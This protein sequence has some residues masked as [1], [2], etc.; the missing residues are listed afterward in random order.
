LSL[1]PISETKS[2]FFYLFY[3]PL[4]SIADTVHEEQKLNNSRDSTHTRHATELASLVE[5]VD[6]KEPVLPP[7]LDS[8]LLLC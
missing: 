2:S 6:G 1:H 4:L 3:F 8:Q 7:L 5:K